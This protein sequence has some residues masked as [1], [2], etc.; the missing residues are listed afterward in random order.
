MGRCSTQ[1]KKFSFI[2][3]YSRLNYFQSL[4][5]K[6]FIFNF[7]TSTKVGTTLVNVKMC[8]KIKS[9][10]YDGGALCLLIRGV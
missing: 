1:E 10:N 3:E 4:M 8:G 5:R 6:I 7:F 2:V 9:Q